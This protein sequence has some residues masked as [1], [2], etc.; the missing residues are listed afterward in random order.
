MSRIQSSGDAELLVGRS[1]LEATLRD[2]ENQPMLLEPEV[3]FVPKL[4]F[5]HSRM[6]L[7]DLLDALNKEVI[8]VIDGLICAENTSTKGGGLHST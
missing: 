2:A 8:N 3:Q 4:I 7:Q 6:R 5:N 1:A